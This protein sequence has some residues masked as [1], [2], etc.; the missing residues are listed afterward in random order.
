M[1]KVNIIKEKIVDLEKNQK[2]QSDY[3]TNIKSSLAKLT[4]EEQI[5]TR[6]LD[7][8]AGAIN[9]Y[10]STV[11]LLNPEEATAPA[12]EVLQGEIVE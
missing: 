3:L 8:I 12:Q 1:D 6:N 11:S 9:A 5:V 10:K 7:T 4:A 2:Q